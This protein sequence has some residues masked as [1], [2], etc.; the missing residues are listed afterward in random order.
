MCGCARGLRSA[1]AA[2]AITSGQWGS[3]KAQP[4]SWKVLLTDPG[5][6]EVGKIFA[7]AYWGPRA[8]YGQIYAEQCANISYLK[9]QRDALPYISYF[10]IYVYIRDVKGKW[11]VCRVSATVFSK[12]G[13]VASDLDGKVNLDN[14]PSSH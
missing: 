11:E 5:T 12:V 1:P 2:A 4:V 3:P 7:T 13:T 14:A 8:S 10:A 9:S 6:E